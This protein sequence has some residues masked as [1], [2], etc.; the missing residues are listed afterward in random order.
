M[1]PAGTRRPAA[2][3]AARPTR[4]S[5]RP[6]WAA[7]STCPP[8]AG[9][10]TRAA[11]RNAR[12]PR[13]TLKLN[14]SCAPA[15][16][17]AA[18][19][20]TRKRPCGNNSTVSPPTPPQSQCSTVRRAGAATSSRPTRDPW[21]AP[22]TQ[23]TPARSASQAPPL[24]PQQSQSFRGEEATAAPP[25]A[26]EWMANYDPWTSGGD[27]NQNYDQ[28]QS[29]KQFEP[30]KKR[31]APSSI[32]GGLSPFRDRVNDNQTPNRSSNEGSA[33]L[34][35][36]R[37]PSQA[38]RC[39]ALRTP[40]APPRPSFPSNLTTSSTAR[41]LTG[42][43]PAPRTP[44]RTRFRLRRISSLPRT[45]DQRHAPPPQGLL[46][47]APRLEVVLVPMVVQRL[48]A[49]AHPQSQP[50]SSCDPLGAL[51]ESAP[52][53][54]CARSGRC[55]C[56]PTSPRGATPAPAR[57]RGHH[58]VPRLDPLVKVLFR[59]LR[60]A[61]RV[62]LRREQPPAPAIGADVRPERRKSGRAALRS[63]DAPPSQSSEASP[64]CP[65]PRAQA[66]AA[67]TPQPSP[68][69]RRCYLPLRR[70][71]KKRAH[72]GAAAAPGRTVT[73][74]SVTTMSPR[75][76]AAAARTPCSAPADALVLFHR[77]PLAGASRFSSA[78]G[79]TGLA[80]TACIGSEWDGGKGKG[81]EGALSW[82]R[83]VVV[84]RSAGANGLVLP[85]GNHVNGSG[86]EHGGG[87]NNAN[88][89]AN[90]PPPSTFSRSWDR[91][92]HQ[93]MLMQQ[94]QWIDL[95]KFF[96]RQRPSKRPRT[97]PTWSACAWCYSHA[98]NKNGRWSR[99]QGSLKFAGS[100][101][102]ADKAM[103]QVLG[104]GLNSTNQ[105]TRLTGAR[106]AAESL[107][108]RHILQLH[109]APAADEGA[110]SQFRARLTTQFTRFGLATPQDG[111]SWR[112]GGTNS[113][114][115]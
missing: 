71:L 84:E 11:R 1:F 4:C 32:R 15:P 30:E 100:G 28:Q 21:T 3:R 68:A 110:A 45:S 87:A 69:L 85:F 63:D 75:A 29:Q 73:R 17:K 20:T 105:Y 89:T 13:T 80:Q 53:R 56:A 24:P 2:S 104:R 61:G 9:R 26:N 74:S 77:S 102:P 54:H 91:D 95:Q 90:G 94:V 25:S 50:H 6:R 59:P 113:W 19:G 51:G 49:H 97:W 98:V 52:R 40:T 86:N 112:E 76:C 66:R 107:A 27:E 18:H 70:A 47:P 39:V 7:S 37:G 93:R 35:D 106:S 42:R 88:G 72:V 67:P 78:V 96:K 81:F 23:T 92:Q 115:K 109:F 111:L 82:W 103:S 101:S 65:L 14:P 5:P 64:G 8:S 38:P 22:V 108:Q 114:R 34:L 79:A 36:V 55:S 44:R 48:R 62:P 83:V 57:V 58:D 16:T 12:P 31:E 10:T 33:N 46:R 43:A 60:D 99:S 41:Q